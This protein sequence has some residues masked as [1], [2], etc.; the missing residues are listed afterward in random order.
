VANVIACAGVATIRAIRD[1]RCCECAGARTQLMTG[2][3]RLQRNIRR[4][5]MCATGSY[6]RYRVHGGNSPEKAR[7]REEVVHA[8]EK[9]KP[10]AAN[11]WNLHKISLGAPLNV[12]ADQIRM[13]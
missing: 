2:L 10:A 8:A 6:D 13:A 1:E 12:T 5:P 7:R 11:L 4:S 3:R 9:G